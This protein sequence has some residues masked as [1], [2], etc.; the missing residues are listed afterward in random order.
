MFQFQPKE[1]REGQELTGVGYFSVLRFHCFM[2]G[3][4]DSDDQHSIIGRMPFLT[5]VIIL[6]NFVLFIS[7]ETH[8]CNPNL[9]NAANQ[10]VTQSQT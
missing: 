8:I 3:N 9:Y 5:S 2:I 6:R 10:F 7:V 4:P 1:R